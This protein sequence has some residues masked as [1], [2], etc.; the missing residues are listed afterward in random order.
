MYFFPL[1][2]QRNLIQSCL[3]EEPGARPTASEVIDQIEL[4]N[5]MYENAPSFFE[6]SIIT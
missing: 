2:L 4:I 5:I 6:R 1:Y 3:A